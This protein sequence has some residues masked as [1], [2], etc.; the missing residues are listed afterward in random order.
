MLTIFSISGVSRKNDKTLYALSSVCLTSD[1]GFSR[2]SFWPQKNQKQGGLLAHLLLSSRGC[3]KLLVL[4]PKKKG[5]P[6]RPHFVFNPPRLRNP[7]RCLFLVWISIF[8]TL[9]KKSFPVSP[10][11]SDFHAS[12]CPCSPIG[13]GF[14]TITTTASTTTIIT[15]ML[16]DPALLLLWDL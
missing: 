13:L 2:S 5:G 11:G 7:P 1:S 4:G 14:L 6:F 9:T 15:I 3:W 16:W 12:T 10:F 8:L